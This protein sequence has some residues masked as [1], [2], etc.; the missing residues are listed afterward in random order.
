MKRIFKDYRNITD[1]HMLLIREKY[2]KGFSDSDL[3]TIKTS[4]GDYLDVLE[5]PT[6]DALYLIRITHD[7][8]CLIEDFNLNMDFSDELEPASKGRN[9]D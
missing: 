2:P 8:L 7:L 1:K 9:E 5:I 6:S 3:T 4:D